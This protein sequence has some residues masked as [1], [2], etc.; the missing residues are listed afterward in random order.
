MW[1]DVLGWSQERVTIGDDGFGLFDIPGVSVAI[2]VN[3]KAEGRDRFGKFDDQIYAND[4]AALELDEN[5]RKAKE[6]ADK[7][8]KE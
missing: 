7:S 6:E 4:E 3:E 8:T 1:T 5:A 2:Y